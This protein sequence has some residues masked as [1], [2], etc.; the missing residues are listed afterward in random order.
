MILDIIAAKD[1]DSLE[2]SAKKKKKKRL[3]FQKMAIPT[4]V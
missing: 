4:G 3:K 1:I 2:K